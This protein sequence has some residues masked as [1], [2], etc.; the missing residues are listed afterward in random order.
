MKNENILKWEGKMSAGVCHI[1][2][3]DLV[4]KANDYVMRDKMDKM[5]VGCF[6]RAGMMITHTA[7]RNL[8]DQICPQGMNKGDFQIPIEFNNELN[9]E[10]VMVTHEIDEG[11]NEENNDNARIIDVE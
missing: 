6:E 8:D 1:L 7:D 3:T 10:S 2:T 9:I 4:G 11:Q 5:N